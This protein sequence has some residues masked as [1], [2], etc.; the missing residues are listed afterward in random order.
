MYLP[1]AYFTLTPAL[2]TLLVDEVAAEATL[3]TTKTEVEVL[4]TTPDCG[5]V[6]EPEVVEPSPP[7]PPNDEVG[8]VDGV[9][10]VGVGVGE[11]VVEAG[12]GGSRVD[13]EGAA[14]GSEVVIAEL[15]A[16]CLMVKFFESY[17]LVSA[18][19]LSRNLS[20]QPTE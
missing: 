1:P 15:I 3:V 14:G 11:G 4:T 19:S 10:E 17:S 13:V 8:E 18:K 2:G 9:V 6:V 20:S 16:G 5:E 12:G 7:L